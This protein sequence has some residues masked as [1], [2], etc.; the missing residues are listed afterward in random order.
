MNYKLIYEKIIERGKL[1]EYYIKNTEMHHIL[2]KSEGGSNKKTNKVELTRKEH[3]L[4]HLL[5]IK[6]GLCLKYCYRHLTLRD[7]CY[8]KEQEAIKKHLK[9]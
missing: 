2:P 3:H 7:Y 9:Y 4:C 5:L 8:I 6:M 1:R